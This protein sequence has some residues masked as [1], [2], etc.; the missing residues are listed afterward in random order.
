MNDAS[1]AFEEETSA[2]LGPGFRCGFLGL[3]HADV[4][5]QRLAEEAARGGGHLEVIAT[6][7]RRCRTRWC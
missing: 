2:A 7:R 1:V 6:A 5:R 4:F 3:L